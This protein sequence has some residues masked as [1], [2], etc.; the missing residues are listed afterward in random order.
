MRDIIAELRSFATDFTTF[1][2]Y[3]CNL[4]GIWVFFMN[5]YG[6]TQIAILP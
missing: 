5:V 1:G 3:F 4:Q 6:I 2:H